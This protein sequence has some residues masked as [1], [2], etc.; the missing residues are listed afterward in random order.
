MNAVERAAEVLEAAE[1]VYTFNDRGHVC[2][3]Y[4][5]CCFGAEDRLVAAVRARREGGQT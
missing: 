5:T 4:E 3:G 2:K 1:G